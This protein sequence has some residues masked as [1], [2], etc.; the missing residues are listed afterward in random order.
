MIELMVKDKSC[1]R[2]N[3]HG[4]SKWLKDMGIEQHEETAD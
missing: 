2:K 4:R 1:N 3:I